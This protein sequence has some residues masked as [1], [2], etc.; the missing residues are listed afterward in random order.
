MEYLVNHCTAPG[1]FSDS[2]VRIIREAAKR[3]MKRLH[4]DASKILQRERGQILANKLGKLN[5]LYLFEKWRIFCGDHN[6][7]FSKSDQELLSKVRRMRNLDVH[8]NWAEVNRIDIYRA[9][10]ILEKA[11][12]AA[13]ESVHR[14]QI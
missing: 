5:D 12:T 3:I 13:M 11:I 4:P 6:L 7:S 2:D 9:A 10:G 8:G 14:K 1:K